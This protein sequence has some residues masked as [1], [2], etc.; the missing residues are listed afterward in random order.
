MSELDREIRLALVMTGGVSLAVWE[1]G[2]S[3]EIYRAVAGE[4]LYGNLLEATKSTMSVDIITGASAG[5]LNGA[6]LA[7]AVLRHAD[8][9]IFGALSSIWLED[10][11]MDKLA[12]KPFGP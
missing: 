9:Q 7:L 10:G 6:F 5:G 4:G 12:R 11:A 3:S 1:G 8:P 2:V